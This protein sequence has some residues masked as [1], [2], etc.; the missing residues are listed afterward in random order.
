MTL[1][2]DNDRVIA[3][4]RTNIVFEKMIASVVTAAALSG[5]AHFVIALGARIAAG[6]LSIGGIGNALYAALSFVMLFFLGGFAVSLAI[7][8]PLFRALERAKCRA[9]WP[10]CLAALA[11]SFVVLAASGLTP[12]VEAP[13]RALFLLPGFGAALLFTRKMRPFW[14]AAARADDPAPPVIRLN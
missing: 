13:A 8:I 5:L 11:A 6:A 4:I 9:A 10:Y 3:S 2:T 14:A 12:S 7:G 1:Q